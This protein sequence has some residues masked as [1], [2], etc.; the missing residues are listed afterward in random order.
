[1]LFAHGW[2]PNSPGKSGVIRPTGDQQLIWSALLQRST[3]LSYCLR[4]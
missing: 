4:S 1:V 3:A 2:T